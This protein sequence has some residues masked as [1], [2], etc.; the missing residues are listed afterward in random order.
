MKISFI[1]GFI[2]RKLGCLEL[3]FSNGKKYKWIGVKNISHICI[4]LNDA[5]DNKSIEDFLKYDYIEESEVIKQKTA[6]RKIDIKLS[7]KAG[8]RSLFIKLVRLKKILLFV[9][10]FTIIGI[11]IFVFISNKTPSFDGKKIAVNAE[12]AAEVISNLTEDTMVIVKGE[13]RNSDMLEIA[14]ALFPKE[15]AN[16]EYGI[17][18]GIKVHLYLKKVKNLTSIDSELFQYCGQLAG[19]TFP[20]SLEHIGENA[21]SDCVALESIKIPKE[22]HSLGSYHDSN[23]FDGCTALKEIKVDSENNDYISVNGILYEK[24]YKGGIESLVVC[25]TGKQGEIV[26]ENG[27]KEISADS[28]GGCKFITTVEIPNTVAKIG[29]GAFFCC[30]ALKNIII[31]DSVETIDDYAFFSCESLSDVVL[32]KRLPT[33][34]WGENVFS[35]CTNLENVTLP[36]NILLTNSNIAYF[37]PSYQNL[38]TIH[39]NGKTYTVTHKNQTVNKATSQ[40]M[41]VRENLKLRTKEAVS[42]NVIAIMS[43]GVKVKIL[44]YGKQ[45]TIDGINANWVKI[46]IQNGAKDVD[47][48]TI[49]SGTVGWC[50]GG[51]LTKEVMAN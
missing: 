3:R 31:P 15:D 33:Y 34:G 7:I 5:K 29:R 45:E 35:A 21:F 40:I 43:A 39:S 32:P 22:V 38:K 8:I 27:I 51:Y 1:S 11:G 26:I 46:E 28:F 50:Y 14:S 47:G 12:N 37:F 2:F 4:L 41:T 10:G 49:K 19:I 9:L 23:P 42:S 48:K 16:G 44:E 25:P 17:K 36:D 6:Q 30:F 13:V 20:D 18:S 24:D